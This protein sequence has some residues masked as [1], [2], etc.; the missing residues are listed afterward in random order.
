M[1]MPTIPQLIYVMKSSNQQS[2]SENSEVE[3]WTFMINFHQAASA[4][5]SV[6]SL[7]H[8]TVTGAR[9]VKITIKIPRA[10]F[11]HVPDTLCGA[12]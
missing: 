6:T 8:E 10:N 12:L 3:F 9:R 1:E 7:N 11:D 5:L 4:W 2:I